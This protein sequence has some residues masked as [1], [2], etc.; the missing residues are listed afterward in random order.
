M[1]WNDSEPD[2]GGVVESSTRIPLYLYIVNQ[3][4]DCSLWGSPWM[5]FVFG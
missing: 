1:S 2:I 5:T 4:N 3:A